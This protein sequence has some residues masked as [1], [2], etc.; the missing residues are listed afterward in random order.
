[1][2]YKFTDVDMILVQRCLNDT[3]ATNILN[4]LRETKITNKL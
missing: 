4:G 1:M 3:S 2:R